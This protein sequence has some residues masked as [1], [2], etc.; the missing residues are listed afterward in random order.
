MRQ[1]VCMVVALVLL[2]VAHGAL[3]GP[4]AFHGVGLASSTGTYS[5]AY[6]VSANGMYATGYAGLPQYLGGDWNTSIQPFVWTHDGGTIGQGYGPNAHPFYPEAYSYS[7]ANDGTFVGSYVNSSDDNVLF[8]AQDGH[9]FNPIAI[10]AYNAAVSADSSTVVAQLNWTAPAMWTRNGSGFQQTSMTTYGMSTNEATAVSNDGSVIV[11][12]TGIAGAYGTQAGIWTNNGQTVTPLGFL[13]TG[14]TGNVSE[15][16]DVSGDGEVVVGSS[17]KMFGTNRS[18]TAVLW[19]VNHVAQELGTLGAPGAYCDSTAEAVNGDGS[20][21]GGGWGDGYTFLAFLWDEVNGMRSLE[22]VL[23]GLGMG[24][25]IAGWNLQAITDM[26]DD[27]NVIAGYG[28]NPLG[29][30]EGFVVVMDTALL[31]PEPATMAL[32]GVGLIG[33][34]RRR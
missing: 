29:K 33:L 18:R 30:S 32:L 34:I 3:A 22:S 6:G 17:R 25:A 20:L 9:P 21:V 4:A 14:I 28:V 19:D 13:Y 23:T 11:G 31:V 15:A 26:S 5:F 10:G 27:G 1:R 16:L 12:R 2:A 8:E 7:I 24:D